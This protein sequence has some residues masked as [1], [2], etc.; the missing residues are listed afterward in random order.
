MKTAII[1]TT[2]YGSVKKC[3]EI[4]KEKTGGNADTYNLQESP[5]IRLEDYDTIIL[6]AS[7]YVGRIQKEMVD[8]CLKNN[9]LLIL[10]RI[11]LFV[12]AGEKSEKKYEY[13]KLFR[14]NILNISISNKVFGDEIYYEKLNLLEK[15]TL[16][17]LKGVRK[18]YSNL[19]SEAIDEFVTDL[20][21]LKGH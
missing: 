10:K 18:S 19:D 14:E 21:L 4:L 1:Y 3:A 9:T 17:I 11:G 6:G 12:C 13:L 20:D 16:F 7:V 2:K 8:F 5:D 15:I